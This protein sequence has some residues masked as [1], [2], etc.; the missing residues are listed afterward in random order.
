MDADIAE[1]LKQCRIFFRKGKDWTDA[2]ELTAARVFQDFRDFLINERERPYAWCAFQ[3]TEEALAML[4]SVE[5]LMT[6]CDST[7]TQADAEQ[8]FRPQLEQTVQAL[9][10]WQPTEIRDVE[11]KDGKA[12]IGVTLDA[13]A[14]T[15][16]SLDNF[17]FYRQE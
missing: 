13:P 2:E 10:K 16:G 17:E 9:N 6:V 11:V 8:E 15:W 1:R 5:G 7:W 3:Q 14:G 4:L 12:I